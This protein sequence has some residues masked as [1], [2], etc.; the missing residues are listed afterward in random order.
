MADTHRFGNR[1][2]LLPY[3]VFQHRLAAVYTSHQV[4]PY[5]VL[6]YARVR[7]HEKRVVR[8]A[9]RVD[10]YI[11]IF[12][13]HTFFCISPPGINTMSECVEPTSC[14]RIS[15][16]NSAAPISPAITLCD[17][18]TKVSRAAASL[19][20]SRATSTT[21][22]PAAAKAWE[23]PRPIPRD[24]PVTRTRLPERAEVVVV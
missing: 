23:I 22:A 11:D 16:Q 14:F 8:Y 4:R 18:H 13:L 19:S 24:P 2:T 3:H 6:N 7:C 15:S 10:E 12:L 21:D 9:G 1:T 17:P 20:A 5:D